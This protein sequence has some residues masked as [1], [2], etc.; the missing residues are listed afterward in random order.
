MTVGEESVEVGVE[1][2][3][4]GDDVASVDVEETSEG[5]EDVLDVGDVVASLPKVKSCEMMDNVKMGREVR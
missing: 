4:V 3:G 5:A 2:V 1:E